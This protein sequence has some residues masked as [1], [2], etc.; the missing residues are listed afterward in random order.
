M[1]TPITNAPRDYAWGGID[2]ITALLG[3]PPTGGPEAELWLGTHPGSPA[4]VVGSGE[5]LGDVVGE[6]PFLMKVL[7]AAE[8]LSLQV[9]PDA[10]QAAAGYAREEAAGVPVDAPERVYRDPHAK[11]EIILAVSDEFE[12][13][14]GFRRAAEVLGLLDRLVGGSGLDDVGTNALGA[15]RDRL[16]DDAVVGRAFL[17]LLSDAPEARDLVTRLLAVIPSRADDFPVQ[18]RL[19]ALHPGDPGVVASLLLNHVVLRRGE[20]LAVAPGTIHGYLR[21]VG[22][23]LLTDSD[24]VVRGGLTP[25]HVDLGELERLLAVAAR[26]PVRVPGVETGGGV[27]YVPPV[28]DGG[29]PPFRLHRAAGA[30]R[31]ALDGPAVALCV[32]GEFAVTGATGTS[33]LGAGDALHASADEG[34]L[35]IDG[36]GELYVAR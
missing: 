4:R 17:W 29:A 15:L 32:A 10:A 34:V 33:R 18:A 23:E 20:A 3:R 12:A 1:R 11:T 16:A 2:A 31:I 19:A 8:P 30:S 28:A 35:E 14:A 7:A 6:L 5:P 13:Q 24:N 21:G 36:A 9:H 27:E 26:D 25:K 22:I